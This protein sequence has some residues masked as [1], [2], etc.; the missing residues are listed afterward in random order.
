MTRTRKPRLAKSVKTQT[1]AA[2]TVASALFS[3]PKVAYTE[4]DGLVARVESK[5]FPV[6][7]KEVADFLRYRR[8]FGYEE[9]LEEIGEGWLK[10]MLDRG[11]V[12]PY[13]DHMPKAGYLVTEKAVETYKLPR[14]FAD[15]R[16]LNL[17]KAA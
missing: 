9:V 10:A 4:V 7:R 15:G 17:A 3:A 1:R 6:D 11:Y 2:L 16:P 5:E 14:T 13:L 8:G 12:I